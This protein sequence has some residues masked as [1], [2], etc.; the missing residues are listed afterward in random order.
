MHFKVNL[1]IL[2]LSNSPEFSPCPIGKEEFLETE[3]LL[4]KNP[5]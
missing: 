4:D 3:A 2:F 5:Y 1:R